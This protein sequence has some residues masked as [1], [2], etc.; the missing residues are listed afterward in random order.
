ML[1]GCCF[2][3][4]YFFHQT[5]GDLWL[6]VSWCGS[7]A[8]PG[9]VETQPGLPGGSGQDGQ[10]GELSPQ[11]VGLRIRQEL[12][13]ASLGEFYGGSRIG[14]AFLEFGS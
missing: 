14:S 10:Q 12:R 6:D 13:I 9:Q 1:V 5:L 2:F 11:G 3:Y 8:L 4:F 7:S